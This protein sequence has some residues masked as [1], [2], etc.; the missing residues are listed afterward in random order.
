M[1]FRKTTRACWSASV[2]FCQWVRNNEEAT[3]GRTSL[4]HQSAQAVEITV[5]TLAAQAISISPV[6]PVV[7]VNHFVKYVW[8]KL[9]AVCRA[10]A[11]SRWC[12]RCTGAACR[13]CNYVGLS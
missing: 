6:S 12:S 3:G 1:R 4:Q 13:G 2:K 10:Q 5:I 9:A 7:A 11:F 8:Q